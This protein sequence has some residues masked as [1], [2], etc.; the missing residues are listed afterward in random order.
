MRIGPLYHW[1]PATRRESILEHGLTIGC[2]PVTHSE[3]FPYLCFATDPQTA[4]NLSAGIVAH[5]SA[6]A[7][8]ANLFQEWDLWQIELHPR[9]EVHPLPHWGPE[10]GEIRIHNNIDADRVW[11]VGRRHADD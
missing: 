7:G 5:L 11:L 4:W 3:K 10:G 1:A 9:D 8:T 2:E 6:L